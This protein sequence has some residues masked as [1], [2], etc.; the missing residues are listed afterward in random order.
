MKKKVFI[1]FLFL[2]VLSTSFIIAAN[3]TNIDTKGYSCLEDKVEGKCS[4][5]ST[6]E[7][8]FT[9]LAIGKCR[10]ELN[11][12]K[13][14]DECWP[15][16]ECRIKTTA[17]AILALNTGTKNA[18]DWLL[19]K[20]IDFEEIDWF[21][22][23]ESNNATSCSV[24]YGG[25]SY[26]FSV[27][28]DKTLSTDA[29]SCLSVY[30]NYWF[31]IDSDCYN[32]EFIISCSNS[33]LTSLLY[34]KKTSSTIYVSEKTSSASGEGSTTEKVVS[35]CL[36][37][38]TSCDYEGTL[39]GALVLNHKGDDI[40]GYLPYLIA[41]ADENPQF[42]PESF[43][44]TLTNDFKVD[45]LSKQ[46]ESQWWAESGD[47][48]YDT[49]LAL[50]P[51]QNEQIAEKTNSKNWLGEIQGNDGCWQGNIRNTA[52]ILYSLWPKKISTGDV[53]MND[54]EDSGYFC[55][56]SASC[57]DEEGLILTDYGGC[58]GTN[59]C[60]NKAKIL[61]SC[62]EQGGELC[63]SDEECLGGSIVSSI[64]S[65]SAKFCCVKGKCGTKEI[66]E[67]ETYGGI[68]KT[69]CSSDEKTSPYT[70]SS[71]VCCTAKKSSGIWLVVLLV[72]LI[73]LTI[74]GIIFRKQLREVLLKT[75]SKLK[76]KFG[77]GKGKPTTKGPGPRFP[78]GPSAAAYPGAVP[79]KII[80]RQAQ[81]APV[82]TP[83]KKPAGKKS[84]FDDVLK[85][86][87][88]IGK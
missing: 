43:L 39:W 15:D 40:S 52:F 62:S 86:L 57:L 29:G 12:D 83:L 25:S 26:S 54:C 27:N 88:E 70:C 74:L 8:I 21:L 46:K 33:F 80:P 79:R 73:I 22:Q 87:K 16:G 24:S 34:K 67:C 35:L 6:E 42:I 9:A 2:L 76:S 48:F 17:Q 56:S 81:K 23:V 49:A 4:S 14:D 61:E 66:S 64:D 60:C 58:F 47:K 77:K 55:M 11:D 71:G 10:S 18:E 3:K 53:E 78:P 20:T 37:E 51:F 68:C 30:G 72:I 75:N 50:L 69:S 1:A 5:L 7:K 44:Y 63:S 28:E 32:E 45:L 31:G 19:D 38:G 41:M 82:R 65:N 36:G 13:D 84:D 59:I 85:K